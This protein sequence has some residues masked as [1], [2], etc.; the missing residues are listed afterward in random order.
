MTNEDT[1]SIFE[2]F[3]RESRV[4]DYSDTALPLNEARRGLVRRAVLGHLSPGR[5]V[6]EIGCGI[7]TLTSEL[8]AAGMTCTAIDFSAEMVKR[9]KALIGT[10]AKVE[11][12]DLFDYKPELRFAA[13]IANGVACYYRDKPR[14]MRHVAELT[15][16]GGLAAIVHRNA[17]FNLFALNQGTVDFVAGEL[18]K[19]LPELAR[20]RISQEL[21][22]ISGL[23]V[24]VLRDQSAELYRSAENP[25]NVAELYADAGFSVNEI[26]YCFIHGSPPRLSSV[27][28]IPGTAELQ[29]QYEDRWEGMFLGS[30]FLVLAKRR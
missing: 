4:A 6:L 2:H 7:G 25:L 8:A 24:P 11:Q 21:N 28:G 13:V 20:R 27:E 10:A 19:D 5:P 26:R 9:A 12:T 29:R 15:E 1:P 18:L 30:Q 3:S 14:F 22:A 16:P 17:L 23:A